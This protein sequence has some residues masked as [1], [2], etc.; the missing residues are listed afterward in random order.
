M[1]LRLL[2]DQSD[3]KAANLPWDSPSSFARRPL[4]AAVRDF[5]W[6]KRGQKC[7]SGSDLA[8]EAGLTRGPRR[9]W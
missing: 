1:D 3:G 8:S 6:D 9:L 2:L 5:A 7:A 4:L